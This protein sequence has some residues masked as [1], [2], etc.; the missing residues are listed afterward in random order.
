M[1]QHTPRQHLLASFNDEA[2]P[3][4]T[5]RELTA[6]S[7]TIVARDAMPTW[8]VC[9]L[10]AQVEALHHTDEETEAERGKVLANSHTA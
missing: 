10:A 7:D 9:I 2:V 4:L 8:D 1:G 3:G 5:P 6:L